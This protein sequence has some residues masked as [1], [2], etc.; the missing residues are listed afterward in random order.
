MV[1]L[2][3]WTNINSKEEK[4]PR[5]FSK[6]WSPYVS[7]MLQ[8][9]WMENISCPTALW[10][11]PAEFQALLRGR[12]VSLG[13]ALCQCS[14]VASKIGSGWGP[15]SF[16]CR[17]G[18]HRSACTHPQRHV[19]RKQRWEDSSVFKRKK[20]QTHTLVRSPERWLILLLSHSFLHL[21]HAPQVLHQQ[22]VSQERDKKI[23]QFMH[24]WAPELPPAFG[25]GCSKKGLS[26]RWVRG[27]HPAAPSGRPSTILLIAQESEFAFKPTTPSLGDLHRGHHGSHTM[28]RN[29]KWE[30]RSTSR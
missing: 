22:E 5:V 29:D 20:P 12:A 8:A 15:S 11:T 6:D 9:G 30:I 19:L 4:N 2:K 18:K 26:G 10:S 7:S 27:L 23:G 13:T 1:S 25:I 14:Y 21:P 17:Q 24:L 16:E 28:S 3:A